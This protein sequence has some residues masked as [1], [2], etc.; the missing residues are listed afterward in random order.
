MRYKVG[1]QSFA[2]SAR[3]GASFSL[4]SKENFGQELLKRA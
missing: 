1:D 4:R 3:K 2:I